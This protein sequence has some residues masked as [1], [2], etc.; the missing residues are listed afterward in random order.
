MAL[1]VNAAKGGFRDLMPATQRD[2]AKEAGVSVSTVSRVIRNE[3]YIS[4]T[5]RHKV[6]DAIQKLQYRP[7]LV[8]RRLKYG[9]TYAFGFV[10]HDVSNPFFSH[11]VKGAE[12]FLRNIGDHEFELILSNTS[13]KADREIKA[14]ELMLSKRVEGIILASTATEECI[15]LVRQVVEEYQIPVVS[16]DNQLGGF[17]LGVVS[18]DNQPGAYKLTSHLLQHGHRRIGIISGLLN[19]SHACE[20]LDGCKQA[21]AEYGLEL[22]MEL[23]AVGNW[24]PEDGYVIT[25]RWLDLAKPPTAIFSSNNF[26]CMGA[27]SALRERN[28]RV[29]E[30]VAIVS[31]DDVEFGYLLQPCLTTLDYS[32]QKIGEEAVRLLL[33]GIGTKGASFSP[34][35]IRLP[36]KL[37]IRESCGCN[38][39]YTLSPRE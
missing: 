18:A 7:D 12:Q 35:H 33:E 22:D 37:V 39:H 9:R 29:P 5:T 32:F 13:G 38:P 28:V 36:V 16:I 23:L 11:A 26:M 1:S 2:V 4:E 25:K 20:R 14:I 6:L 30:D 31:F 15:D 10:M 8:A 17:E 34:Q 21:L 27:L 19:E 3:R 24:Y